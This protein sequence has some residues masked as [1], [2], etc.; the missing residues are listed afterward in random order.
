MPEGAEKIAIS[1]DPQFQEADLMAQRDKFQAKNPG[2][3]A[4]LNTRLLTDA[5]PPFPRVPTLD[6]HKEEGDFAKR[7]EARARAMMI[8]INTIAQ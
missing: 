2:Q 3:R 7:M 1:S 4:S 8:G 5:V 6:L